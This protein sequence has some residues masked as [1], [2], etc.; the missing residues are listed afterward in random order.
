MGGTDKFHTDLGGCYID[1][2]NA[3]P[4]LVY[5]FADNIR[6]PANDVELANNAW[7]VRF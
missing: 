3:H 1:R 7:H 6:A 2:L 4:L 5:A